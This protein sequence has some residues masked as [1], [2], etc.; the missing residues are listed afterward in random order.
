MKDKLAEES[1]S[2]KKALTVFGIPCPPYFGSQDKEAD[3]LE[4]AVQN[5]LNDG[6]RTKDIMSEGNKEVSTTQMGDAIISKLQ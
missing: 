4:K 1:I 5:V 6:L 3:L 2:S